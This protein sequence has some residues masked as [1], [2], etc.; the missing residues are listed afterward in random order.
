MVRSSVSSSFVLESFEH[1]PAGPGVA[2]ARVAGRAEQPVGAVALLI[3][4]GRKAH[5]VAPLSARDGDSGRWAFSVRARAAADPRT[6][7][8]LELGEGFVVDLP[9]PEPRRIAG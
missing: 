5:G 8:A 1:V 3:D 2:L 6:A 4:D 9:R 7:W